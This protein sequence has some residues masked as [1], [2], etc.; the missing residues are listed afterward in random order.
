MHS[1]KSGAGKADYT[2][3]SLQ[4]E[5]LSREP[6][7]K[8]MDAQGVEAILIFP[9]ESST[10]EG[11][12]DDTDTLYANLHAYNR[13]YNDEWGFN[14]QDRIFAPPMISMRDLDRAVEEVEWA[15]GL[16]ARVF[17]MRPGPVDGRS[18]ADEHFDPVWA[19]INEAGAT[20]A[21]HITETGYN[22]SVSALWGE[23]LDPPVHYQSAWQFSHTY[24]DRPI[25]ETL[26]AL[27]FGNLF[28]KFPRLRVA[29]VEHGCE[30][31]PYLVRRMDKMRAMARNG[32]WRGGP[33]TERP[34]AI[35]KRHVLV[36]PFVEDDVP[37]VADEV[38]VECLVLGSDFPHGEG[39]KAPLDF[40]D[41]LDGMSQEDVRTIMRDNGR[42]L[43]GRVNG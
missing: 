19:R 26:S 10:V 38:G 8:V 29:S 21:Y 17:L 37:K 43:L 34:S 25:M 40:V 41:R 42:R 30:W 18:P 23:E 28:G 32:P 15:L 2:W 6:R 12:I 11:Y 22:K 9:S 5:Y 3:E 31:V 4:P 39:T 13:Y 35:F 7:L 36:T 16:G 27:V 20:V 24:G 14:Y 1:L 33:L